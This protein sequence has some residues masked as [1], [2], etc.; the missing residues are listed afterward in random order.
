MFIEPE[1]KDLF[2][3]W[4]K[5]KKPEVATKLLNKLNNIIQTAIISYAGGSDP[6]T[7]GQAKILTLE[8]LE[9]YDPS[10]SKLKTH[11]LTRLQRLRR[12]IGQNTTIVRL[13]EKLTLEALQVQKFIDEFTDKFGREPS[14]VEISDALGMSIK[15]LNK[16]RKISYSMPES[17]LQTINEEGKTENFLPG[18]RPKSNQHV[19]DFVYQSLSPI[20]QYILEHTMG[21]N[22]KKIIAKSEIAKKLKVSPGAISQR[23]RSIQEKINRISKI[24]IGLM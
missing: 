20:D 18:I 17:K 4:K 1:Y 15:R 16:V 12:N 23:L 9:N 11:L 3:E 10:K 13:P 22:G 19:I 7:L 14:D 6:Y 21:L 8:A 24:P 5:T 2:F